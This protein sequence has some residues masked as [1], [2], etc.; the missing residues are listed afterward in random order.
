MA[1]RVLK[2]EQKAA[3]TKRKAKKKAKITST[4]LP[5]T[6]LSSTPLLGL[7]SGTPIPSSI[8][9]TIAELQTKSD[10]LSDDLAK[11][12]V[13]D[14][15]QK[16]QDD[17]RAFLHLWRL[18]IQGMLRSQNGIDV[19]RQKRDQWSAFFMR[20]QAVLTEIGDMVCLWAPSTALRSM[21]RCNA[22]LVES[23][24][25]FLQLLVLLVE[26]EILSWRTKGQWVP[27]SD[28]SVKATLVKVIAMR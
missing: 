20:G 21:L 19:V 2:A 13:Q 11:H 23:V 8:Y 27:T 3:E 5:P 14:M 7:P 28:D 25:Q 17:S 1:P 6:I 24:C 22:H 9:A 26:E 15:H 10:A 18:D 12:E 16:F 4:A